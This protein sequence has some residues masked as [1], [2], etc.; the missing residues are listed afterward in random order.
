[1]DIYKETRFCLKG[2]KFGV[3]WRFSRL[4][5]WR[6]HWCGSGHCCCVAR[7]P[8][9]R[10]YTSC[11]YGQSINPSIRGTKFYKFKVEELCSS[12]HPRLRYLYIMFF[13]IWLVFL[14][15]FR[16]APM[17]YGS[18]QAR[19]QIGAASTSLCHSHSN[20]VGSQP[21]L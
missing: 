6:C 10:T 19:D 8:G 4:G 3:Y 15:F 13:F 7:I 14:S 21:C 2:T 16:A 9:L 12:S 11:R 18:F 1:M 20:E 17:A 5:I